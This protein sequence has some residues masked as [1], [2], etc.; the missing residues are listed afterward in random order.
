MRLV[1][2]LLLLL[3]LV[4]NLH[5][6]GIEQLTSFDGIDTDPAI[7]PDGK[8]MVYASDRQKTGRFELWVM[9]LVTGNKSLFI[10]DIVVNSP[11][12]WDAQGTG[13]VAAL[14][15][16]G[17]AERIR[18][19]NFESRS[20]SESIFSAPAGSLQLFPDLSVDNVTTA[21]AMLSDT[22]TTNWDIYLG[23]RNTG[24]MTVVAQ[25]PYRDLWP[26]FEK[27]GKTLVYFSR[28]DTGGKDDEIYRYDLSKGVI[29]AL[30]RSPGHDFVP[31]PSPDGRQIAFVSKR[32]PENAVFVMDRNG[33]NVRR[34]SPAGYRA[35]SPT[36]GPNGRTL[37]VTL[38][39]DSNPADIYRIEGVFD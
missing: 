35:G 26:R 16:E 11:V 36:W 28:R 20:V 18:Y 4:P 22:K 3:F 17:E 8:W 23:N 19:V 6:Q 9:N 15:L 13:F 34:I 5:A 1:T 29:Q 39:K 24:E 25:S 27:D 12:A 38:R 32:S 31:H 21:F 33:D 30:T 10:Q 14:S 37:F 2:Q 7:S